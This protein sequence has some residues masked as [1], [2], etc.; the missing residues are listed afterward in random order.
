MISRS[1]P[2]FWHSQSRL[3]AVLLIRMAEDLDGVFE[4][5]LALRYM[6]PDANL[7]SLLAQRQ[8][9]T[10]QAF[11][12]VGGANESSIIE[13][14]SFISQLC[15][16][17]HW[18]IWHWSAANWSL[19]VWLKKA[20]LCTWGRRRSCVLRTTK[21][22]KKIELHAIL[23]HW[24]LDAALSIWKAVHGIDSQIPSSALENC[25]AEP[26]CGFRVCKEITS[27]WIL[28]V[29]ALL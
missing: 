19:H 12:G 26:F 5:A 2:S 22:M 3:S 15:R 8:T 16:T 13:A 29:V 21:Y 25:R 28:F 27:R 20:A 17:E 9:F 11:L 10:P 18:S 23:F 14:K 1:I 6:L 7:G 4:R 24:H